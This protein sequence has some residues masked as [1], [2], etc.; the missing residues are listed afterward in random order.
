MVKG[1]FK[2]GK[3]DIFSVNLFFLR[4]FFSSQCKLLLVMMGAAAAMVRAKPFPRHEEDE[5]VEVVY[6]YSAERFAR[7]IAT[8]FLTCFGTAYLIY[9][10]Q[11]D[12][13]IFLPT[14][15]TTWDYAPG[16]FISRQ[17]IGVG[18]V[19]LYQIQYIISFGDKDRADAA[20][21][22]AHK[23]AANDWNKVLLFAA[24]FA[25]LCL[26]IVGAVCSSEASPECRGNSKIHY[27]AAITFFVVY[28]IY[29]VVLLAASKSPRTGA[30]HVFHWVCVCVSILS[31]MRFLVGFES[32][33]PVFLAAAMNSSSFPGLALFEWCDVGVIISFTASYTAEVGGQYGVALV[34]TGTGT[35]NSDV[36]NDKL[37][38]PLVKASPSCKPVWSTDGNKTLEIALRYA[39]GT[40][41][42]CLIVSIVFDYIAHDRVPF[43]S[44]T[45]VFPPGNYISRW[46]G[47]LG[48]TYLTMFHVLL[49]HVHKK[50][51]GPLLANVL[52]GLSFIAGLALSMVMVVS[53]TEDRHLH[54][55][56]AVITFVFYD[57]HIVLF[58]LFHLAHPSGRERLGRAWYTTCLIIFAIVFKNMLR[59]G[60][61]PLSSDTEMTLQDAKLFWASVGA[62]LEWTD[63]STILLFLVRMP[64]WYG[65]EMSKLKY[66]IFKNEV[67]NSISI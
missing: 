34:R 2:G 35:V 1:F 17:A 32:H 22:T 14:L 56:S 28:D 47:I 10:L 39:F 36:T 51:M 24:L 12:G 52:F 59:V 27:A 38:E 60:V 16:N 29:M 50:S 25:V 6:S 37:C 15:S 54:R 4:L 13:P 61:L 8:L 19:G 5:V 42:G 55:Q 57:L 46:A 65:E 18:C 11:S 9:C 41:S 67:E 3:R 40:L 21:V 66:V 64:L 58:V 48:T 23:T 20:G 45:F 31:K 7:I 44:D 53:E 26:S 49:H 43:I 33:L 30:R 62:V 63:A